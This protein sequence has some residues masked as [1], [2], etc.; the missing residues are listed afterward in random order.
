MFQ[1]LVYSVE[2][3]ANTYQT[4]LSKL[5]ILNNKLLRILQLQRRS[6]R[7]PVG[8][9]YKTFNT[10]TLPLMHEYRIL[11]F[12]HTFLYNREKLPEVFSSYFV[13]NSLL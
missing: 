4:Y 13:Q 6:V 11:I 9:L 3:Y 8:K 7:T 2:I 5:V 12:V 1:H 10:L